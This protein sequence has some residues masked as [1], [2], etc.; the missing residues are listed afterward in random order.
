MGFDLFSKVYTKSIISAEA[1]RIRLGYWFINN[2]FIL[3][4]KKV[5]MVNL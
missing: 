4:N 3:Y 1:S 5:E 2:H